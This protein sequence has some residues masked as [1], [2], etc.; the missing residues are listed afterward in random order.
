MV[1]VR[2][3]IIGLM[4][5][6]S[7]D[8]L[9]VCLCEFSLESRKWN[10]KFLETAFYPYTEEWKERLHNANRLNSVD[11][12]ILNHQLGELFAGF[13]NDFCSHNEVEKKQVDC[14]GSHGHTVFHQ[15]S[16]KITVQ[17][18]CGTTLAYKTGIKV[19][20]D[21]R[22]KDV[23]AG[24]QGAPLV[25]VGD[26]KLFTD[27]ADGFL[28]IGGFSNLSIKK[29]DT[30]HAFDVCPANLPLNAAAEL[31]GMSYDK[32]GEVAQGGYL[33]MDLLNQLNGINHYNELKPNSLGTEWL[34]DVFNP[35]LKNV[36]GRTALRTLS[37][38][39]AFQIANR[40][41]SNNLQKVLV[42]GGG[43]KNIFLIDL[44]KAQSIADI[45]V[46]EE[47]LIDFKEAL[48][49]AFLACLY[50]EN[51]PNCL[52]TVTGASEDVCSGVLHRP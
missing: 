3:K 39:I 10:Y 42:T 23:I 51:Q 15:P 30:I 19:V 52:G 11:L 41:N 8:G 43:A 2:R 1:T 33:D 14:I 37:E 31:L 24:G 49:F 44:I 40:I 5:G 34:K 13:V 6:T 9:D 48:I 29:G 20:N 17:I 38:H 46:P 12:Y 7:T 45:I 21:F 27:V 4:S 26:L 32:N 16:N 50:L 47:Q 22:I 18:G 35:Y 36:N 25:P 28:N